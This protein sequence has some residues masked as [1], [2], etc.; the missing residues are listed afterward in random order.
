MRIWPFGRETRSETYTD[1]LLAVLL[2]GAEGDADITTHGT[3]AEEIAVGLW[4]RAFASA[5]VTPETAS[6]AA[7]TPEVLGQIGRDLVSCGESLW[8]ITVQG[9]RVVLERAT[10][11]DV[12]GFK[13]WV[14]KLQFA[15]PSGMVLRTL[16]A[17]R[18]VH[19]T[20]AVDSK[21]PWKG[22]GPFQKALS[23]LRL[24]DRLETR[25]AD[26]S[27]ARVGSLIPVPRVDQN[28]QNDINVLKG[29]A[30]LVESTASGWNEGEAPKGDFT[31]RRLGFSPPP[32]IEPIRDGVGRSILAAAGVPASL[33]GDSTGNEAR[34]DYRRF[35]HS[36]IQ[37]VAKLIIGELRDKLDTPDLVLEFDELGAADIAGR[38]RAFN[39]LV[40]GGM[41]V[42]KAAGVTGLLVME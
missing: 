3:A 18:V 20:Y 15:F 2:E 39:S 31:P 11:H 37:A 25:L 34:E 7:L 27:G 33:L 17:S 13:D 19:V 21:Q 23:T 41:E 35:L 38:A 14:Y 12:E 4:G 36:T 10:A 42:E 1:A 29:K 9:G 22:V 30:V 5:R 32:T 40:Q 28:L 8:E 24:G 26:E 16:P 6:T